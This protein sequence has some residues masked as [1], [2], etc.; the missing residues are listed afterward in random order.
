[1]EI[2]GLSGS[3]LDGHQQSAQLVALLGAV[4]GEGFE[5]FSILSDERRGNLLWLAEDL[6]IELDEIVKRR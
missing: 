2:T 1:M 4:T 6:A 3:V 5:T